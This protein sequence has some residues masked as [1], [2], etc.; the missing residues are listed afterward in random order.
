MVRGRTA[1]PGYTSYA[2]LNDLPWRFPIFADLEKA[3][4]KH[5]GGVRAR[6]WASTW[7]TSKLKCDSLWINILREGGMHASHIHTHSVISRRPPMLRCRKGP[8]R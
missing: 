1:I 3:L 7:A 6:T 8:R 2:S 5:V 4:D